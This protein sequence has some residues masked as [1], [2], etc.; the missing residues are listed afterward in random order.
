MSKSNCIWPIFTPRT[1]PTDHPALAKHYVFHSPLQCCSEVLSSLLPEPT[2]STC[3]PR[4]RSFPSLPGTPNLKSHRHNTDK[5][6]SLHS[7]SPVPPL[8]I[9][10]PFPGAA[11]STVK[12][13]EAHSNK[14]CNSYG[15][16]EKW[17]SFHNSSSPLC[18]TLLYWPIF[19]CW[20]QQS[21]V[22]Q[23]RQNLYALTSE[24]LGFKDLCSHCHNSWVSGLQG[25]EGN[26]TRHIILHQ[27]EEKNRYCVVTMRQ[28]QWLQWSYSC[29]IFFWDKN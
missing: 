13:A 24:N 7:C 8:P 14:H 27:C 17:T 25:Y 6:P 12:A 20:L 23:H 2:H 15:P 10:P 3:L 26:W 5:T 29:F 9:L 18:T 4:E 16:Q 22:K 1:C 21:K 28:L 11:C 19:Y